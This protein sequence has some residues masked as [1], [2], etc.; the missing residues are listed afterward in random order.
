VFDRF[1]RVDQARSREFAS[2]SG[3]GLAIAAWIADVHRADIRATN[4]PEG[5]AAFCV[6]FKSQP[7]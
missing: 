1:Y 4:R 7:D 3:L 6:R 2:G 5:G